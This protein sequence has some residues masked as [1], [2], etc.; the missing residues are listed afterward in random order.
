MSTFGGLLTVGRASFSNILGTETEGNPLQAATWYCLEIEAVIH[1]S[2]GS[3]KVCKNGV[4]V[5]SATAAAAENVKAFVIGHAWRQATIL[6]STPL[7]QHAWLRMTLSVASSGCST[8]CC[9]DRQ[10]RTN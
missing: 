4:E 7:S 8:P 6:R 2:T 9:T 3:V 10:E 5:I 1:G